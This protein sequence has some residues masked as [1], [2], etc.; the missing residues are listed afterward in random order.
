MVEIST[1]VPERSLQKDAEH[2]L[3]PDQRFGGSEDRRT[4][5][6]TRRIDLD[7]TPWPYPRPAMKFARL[8]PGCIVF[9]F[10][11]S[12]SLSFLLLHPFFPQLTSASGLVSVY[13]YNTASVSADTYVYY[14]YV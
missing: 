8:L 2:Q 5:M 11:F 6:S 13:I 3:V 4:S 7:P 10:F 1:I 14:L 9:A 12:L